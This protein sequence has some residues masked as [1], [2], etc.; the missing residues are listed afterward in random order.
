[1]LDEQINALVKAANVL[2]AKNMTDA[3][4]KIVLDKKPLIEQWLNDVESYAKERMQ[5]GSDG[6]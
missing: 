4:L 2:Q 6:I 3:H 1:M 5:E